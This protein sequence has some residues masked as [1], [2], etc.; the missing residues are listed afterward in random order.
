[1]RYQS[2]QLT[3]RREMPSLWRVVFNHLPINLVDHDTL[4]ELNQVTSE[5]EGSPDAKVVIFESANPDCFLA[6]WDT[7]SVSSAE[8][9]SPDPSWMDIGL[10]L[11]H[12]PVISIA[13][14]R[15]RAR[16]IGSEI[17]LG[18]DMRFASIEKTVL[19]QPE[20]GVGMVPGGGAMERLPMLI[21]RARALEIVVG[22]DDFDALTAERY[23]WINR[24]LPDAQLDE[25]VT[26][27][28]QRIASF[29]K[30]AA[31]AAKRI[32][33]RDAIPSTDKLRESQAMFSQ[34]FNWPGT[35][36]RGKRSLELGMGKPGDFEMRFGD[37]LPG[38]IVDAGRN[39]K[40][41]A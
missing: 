6:H 29:D 12:M 33:N 18:C 30:Q 25:F 9:G 2:K 36:A 15:G 3:I 20:V 39:D 10:R 27:L 26:G 37:Y 35:K 28:A 7:S 1:M 38:L 4:R 14:I 21:G 11:A 34:T 8:P 41:N 19:G 40:F 17:A 32:I 23:G 13:S 22:A 16:G 5:L 24:A 31:A